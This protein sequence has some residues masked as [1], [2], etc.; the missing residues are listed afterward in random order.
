[1]RWNTEISEREREILNREAECKTLNKR[2]Q[3]RKEKKKRTSI[4]NV[5]MVSKRQTYEEREIRN[6]FLEKIYSGVDE[7]E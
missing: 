1:M 3:E 5:M 4:E 6:N 7:W 2:K